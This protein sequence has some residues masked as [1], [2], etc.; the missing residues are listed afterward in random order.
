[1]SKEKVKQK[2]EVS[3]N[4]LDVTVG[5]TDSDNTNIDLIKDLLFEA[6]KELEDE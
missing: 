5:I 6:L 2:I 4:Y 1:M 3:L